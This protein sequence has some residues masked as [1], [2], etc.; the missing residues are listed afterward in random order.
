MR[1]TNLLNST[2][3]HLALL[4]LC[5][6]APLAAQQEEAS[7]LA[8]DETSVP[9]A[10]VQ[11]NGQPFGIRDLISAPSIGAPLVTSDNVFALYTISR[12]DAGDFKR[13]TKTYLRN[14][15]TPESAEIAIDA[16]DDAHD[17]AFDAQN[18][19][20]FLSS[21]G[22]EY[23]RLWRSAL[24]ADGTFAP[25]ELALDAGQE[26][27]GYKLAPDSHKVAIWGRVAADCTTF[28]CAKEGA[29][30]AVGSGRLYEGDIGFYRHWDSWT[31]P[32]VF[33]RIFVYPLSPDAMAAPIAADGA[34]AGG[35]FVGDSPIMPFGGADD[36]AWRMDSAGLWFAGRVSNAKE[37][38]S[39]NIDIW[40][41][42]L[43]GGA[44]LNTTAANLAT[45]ILPTPSPDGRYLAYLAMARPGYEADR[46]AI[47]IRD[48]ATGRIRV[49]AD[50]I[51]RS[52]DSLSWSVDARYIYATAQDVLDVPIFKIDVESGAAAKLD[53]FD[54]N[55]AHISSV[56]PLK[57]G[58]IMFARD[59]L[60]T[61]AD[62]FMASEGARAVPLTTISRDALAP[63]QSVATTRF[64]F[65]G[66]N[67]DDVWGQ[68]TKPE[69]A[70]APL[71]AILYV[72]G[73]PQGSFNDAW[74]R[75]WNP[76]VL[77]SQGYAVISVDFHGS[78]G[79]GQDFT[80][81]I[82]QDWGGKPL[83]DLQKGFAAALSRDPQID[84][85]RAC[86]MG[87]SYGGY[88]MN[89]IA[90]NWPDR[91]KC[92]VQH[93]GL[94]DMRSFYYETEELW[95][96][97]WDFGG[98]YAARSATYEKWNPV[99]Y[100]DNWKTPMLVI[101]GEKDFR[102]PY[103]QGLAAFTALQERNIPSQLL[104]FPDENHWVLKPA[105]SAQWHDT[106]FAWLQ[107]WLKN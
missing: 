52:F 81:A 41:S 73:G 45:D 89:W 37:P 25:A 35:G 78:T 57:S 38:T 88:M 39:T 97:R 84:G 100:V 34:G 102:V 32:G 24:G 27:A 53:L 44:P 31:Q 42:D 7:L 21:R 56:I 50:A 46:L 67:G 36:V 2:H 64:R 16:L 92:L 91:F 60:Q 23:A 22:G 101:T 40:Y 4:T 86:A 59:S 29:P 104:V 61:P 3:I 10:H 6:G 33:N 13:K 71:P 95:F 62:L 1:N 82:N 69:G 12:V 77:A 8:H 18:I 83:E 68:I 30:T 94:F 70:G 47:H 72:H 28:A 87:A 5:C 58:A 74:S 54:G 11:G 26:I 43:S 20:Y 105:N 85:S 79:Y 106:V 107:R 103:T 51:D 55:E 80:D 48:L 75:R 19:L 9:T 99:N 93:D 17:F 49:L 76:R 63:F 14:L 98:S 90:G 96:P 15:N 65:K 66:A